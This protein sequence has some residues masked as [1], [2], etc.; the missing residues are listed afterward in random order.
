MESLIEIDD[1]QLEKMRYIEHRKVVFDYY[2]K[3][4]QLGDDINFNVFLYNVRMSIGEYF[5]YMKTDYGWGAMPENFN[6]MVEKIT[7]EEHSKMKSYMSMY[8]EE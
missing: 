7:P 2:W 4:W 8:Y 1:D 3:K 5:L 6:K